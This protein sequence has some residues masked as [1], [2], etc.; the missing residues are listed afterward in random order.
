MIVLHCPLVVLIGYL[1]II[2]A[3][4]ILRERKCFTVNL[5]EKS[6]TGTY[7]TSVRIVSIAFEFRFHGSFRSNDL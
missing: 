1:F 5:K 4:N 7:Y 6:I 3:K 2:F